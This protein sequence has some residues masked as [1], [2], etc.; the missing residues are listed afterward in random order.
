MLI[1][2]THKKM[3]ACELDETNFARAARS[4]LRGA[5]N[6]AVVVRARNFEIRLRANSYPGPAVSIS[7]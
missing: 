6:T 4:R 3:R 7:R 1:V 2:G 5:I